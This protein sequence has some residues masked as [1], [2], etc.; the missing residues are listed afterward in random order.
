M[1]DHEMAKAVLK[2]LNL[3]YEDLAGQVKLL[4]QQT[5]DVDSLAG[6]R[7]PYSYVVPITID[8]GSDELQ[9]N[10]VQISRAGPFFADRLLFTLRIETLQNGGDASWVGRYLPI[11]SQRIY[12]NIWAAGATG[13][14][15]DMP[16]L[17]FEWS[18][19]SD[20]SDRQRSDKYVPG[21]LMDR[22]DGDGIMS[23]SDV[24]APGTTVTVKVNPLR[25]IGNNTP[26]NAADGV[27][28]YTMTAVFA[29]Y[30]IIQPS[31]V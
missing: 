15:A 20:S 25:A 2:R 16:P 26:W 17:D 11:S 19:E 29:G 6:K 14:Q 18:Y 23:V 21:E 5:L 3:K 10:S 22:Y 27:L 12:P 31:Q 9:E 28:T 4:S 1:E 30:K 8:Q 24:F 7:V 13:T